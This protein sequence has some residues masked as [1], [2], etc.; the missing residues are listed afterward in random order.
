MTGSGTRFLAALLILSLLV[1]S[2][3]WFQNARLKRELTRVAS[4]VIENSTRT[5][6]LRDL[7][8][9]PRPMIPTADTQDVRFVSPGLDT[10]SITGQPPPP[11]DPRQAWLAE[12]DRAMD[13]EF[14]RLDAREQ[15]PRDEAELA[16]IRELKEKLLKLDELYAELDATP[17]GARKD[18]LQMQKQQLMGDIIRLSRADRNQRL[19]VLAHEMGIVNDEDVVRWITSIDE[20]YSET[21]LDW[22]TLFSRSP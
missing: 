19:S 20:I 17:D 22:A 12:F 5:S 7:A 9:A 4:L 10:H 3:T 15:A 1:S 21:H 14:R 6:P 2:Y 11:A 16:M 13:Q 18:L 8:H